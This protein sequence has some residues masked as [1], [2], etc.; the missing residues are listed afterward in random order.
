MVEARLRIASAVSESGSGETQKRDLAV[1]RRAPQ[2]ERILARGDEGP[3]GPSREIR[4]DHVHS[5]RS[6][7]CIRLARR[8]LLR[9]HCIGC[10]RDDFGTMHYTKEAFVRG[11]ER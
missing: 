3:A 9:E 5:I 11:I 10:H 6:K 8:E 1:K 7:N 4:K 2:Q